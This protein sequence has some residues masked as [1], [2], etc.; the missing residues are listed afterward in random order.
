[1]PN[2]PIQYK[3][4][5]STDSAV[6]HRGAKTVHAYSGQRTAPQNGYVYVYA[7]NEIV[8]FAHT[9][10]NNKQ[11]HGQIVRF[12]HSIKNNKQGHGQINA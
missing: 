1:M 7:T 4:T 11:V 9:I 12:A 6:I 5:Y 2:K 10:K 8:R 3:H